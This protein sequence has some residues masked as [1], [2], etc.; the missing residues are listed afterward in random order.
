MDKDSKD[1]VDHTV[2]LRRG[3]LSP[4]TNCNNRLS[5]WYIGEENPYD[6]RDA[7]TLEFRG[8]VH[9]QGGEI[10]LSKSVL[11]TEPIMV[12]LANPNWHLDLLKFF[13][14]PDWILAI[15]VANGTFEGV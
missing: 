8:L 4:R 12:E 6:N 13:G 7:P 15:D 10:G 2:I 14:V 5:V 1:A 9:F 3:G 11:Y